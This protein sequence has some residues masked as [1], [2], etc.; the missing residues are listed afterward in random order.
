MSAEEQWRSRGIELDSNR[1]ELDKSQGNANCNVGV[2][3]SGG[4]NEDALE[5]SVPRISGSSVG[6]RPPLISVYLLLTLEV[7]H[8]T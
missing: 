2:P 3:E 1:A 8:L 6:K 5:T 4:N 7:L